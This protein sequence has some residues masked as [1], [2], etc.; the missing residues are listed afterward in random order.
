MINS[1]NSSAPL[2]DPS[3]RRSDQQRQDQKGS[4]RSPA[5]GAGGRHGDVRLVIEQDEERGG[6]IYK[7]IDRETGEVISE[8]SRDDVLKM[9]A[10]PSYTVGKVID[11]SA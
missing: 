8:L 1:V 4:G 11:T 5:K 10:D 6:L 7:L 3:D 2:G 9:I